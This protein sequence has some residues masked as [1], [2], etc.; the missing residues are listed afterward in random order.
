MKTITTSVLL[1]AAFLGLM[2][3]PG[4]SSSTVKFQ[5]VMDVIEEKRVQIS[6]HKFFEFLSDRSIPASK[7]LQFIPYWTYFIMVATDALEYWM[8]IPEPKTELE[9]QINVFIEEDGFHYNFFLHDV[10]KIAGYSLDHFGSYEGV[11]RH[12]WGDDSKAVRMLVYTWMMG[13]KKSKD[14]LITMASF[15]AVEAGLQ[16]LFETL[17]NHVFLVEEGYQN[18]KYF[19]QLHIDLERNH[20]VTDRWANDDELVE[21]RPL[22]EYDVTEEVKNVALEVIEDMFYW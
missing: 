19:G 21:F 6:Q 12:L 2:L 22:E 11:L 4:R 14:P 10:E 18:M 5:E 9:H 13:V 7:R 20:T 17:Y 8:R 15:E 1:A 3:T 16:S